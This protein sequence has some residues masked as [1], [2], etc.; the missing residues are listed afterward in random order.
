MQAS[1]DD[2]HA[3]NLFPQVYRQEHERPTW[4]AC[5]PDVSNLSKPWH[6]AL[7]NITDV[8]VQKS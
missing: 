6:A 5:T 1:L 8:V 4:A 7:T 3:D 2:R